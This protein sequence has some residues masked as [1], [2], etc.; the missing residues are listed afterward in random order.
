MLRQCVDRFRHGLQR[1]SIRL[2]RC[3]TFSFFRALRQ[4]EV[5]EAEQ[6]MAVVRHGDA[7]RILGIG[8]RHR[9]QVQGGARIGLQ[10]ALDLEFVTIGGD[11]LAAFRAS[12]SLSQSGYLTILASGK[13]CCAKSA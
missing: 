13:L 11:H 8:Q 1:F 6:L 7:Q 2:R 12:T 4:I 10:Q 9:A 3:S 5:D